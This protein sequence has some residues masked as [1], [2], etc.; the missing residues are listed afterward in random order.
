MEQGR[1]SAYFCSDDGA[2]FIPCAAL[3]FDHFALLH[4][5]SLQQ[6]GNNN[7]LASS[8]FPR[9]VD[10][11]DRTNFGY[12]GRGM[13]LGAG[14]LSKSVGQRCT[15]SPVGASVGTCSYN[16]GYTDFSRI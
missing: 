5:C 13:C 8:L 11:W 10:W 1:S 7:F 14:R 9:S 4:L 6:N 3:L 2:E 16:T 15:Q 12:S